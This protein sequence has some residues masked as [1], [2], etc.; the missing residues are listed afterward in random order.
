MP[1]F[2]SGL[3]LLYLGLFPGSIMAPS[4]EWQILWKVQAKGTDMYA[5]NLG[6]PFVV[7]G[8]ELIKLRD[9]GQLFRR[10]SNKTLGHISSVDVSNP[11]K[12]LVFYKDFSRI[13]F[14]DN[15][16][17]ENGTAIN[18][19][20][21][22]LEQTSLV[23]TS[24]DN[25]FWLFEPVHFRLIRFN[26]HLQESVRVLNLNQVLNGPLQPIALCENENR[27][28]MNDPQRGIILFD[29]FGTYVKTIPLKGVRKFQVTGDIIIYADQDEFLKIFN[30][31]TLQQTRIELP[32]Q[33]YADWQ[34]EIERLYMLANDSLTAFKAP[35][36]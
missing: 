1:I 27:L 36:F 19:D 22:D 29:V 17:S 10:Y 34:F 2:L 4:E 28:F 33:M 5:D 24:Y 16:L 23:C 12:I 3:L 14:L 9:D 13:V 31:K 21:R 20:E 32:I 30:L 6:N 15:T 26:Q 35:G 18:L 7:N 25:G 8:D 11:L